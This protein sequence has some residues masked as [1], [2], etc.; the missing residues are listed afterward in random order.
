MSE[1]WDHFWRSLRSPFGEVWDHLVVP[2]VLYFIMNG[3]LERGLKSLFGEVWNHFL[4]PLVLYSAMKGL[5]S[6]VWDH[7]LARFEITIWRGLR[8]PFDTF[9]F[10][11]KNERCFVNPLGNPSP[12]IFSS[13]APPALKKKTIPVFCQT[14][15]CC[16][17]CLPVCSSWVV[18]LKR[19]ALRK[20]RYFAH[21]YLMI[22]NLL[23]TAF[24][25][26]A[27]ISTFETMPSAMALIK[28]DIRFNPCLTPACSG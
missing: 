4:I 16:M 15:K 5:L 17:F 9:C 28:H 7:F 19:N 6:N 27:S 13:P 10:A 11:F 3:A 23:L 24:L 21:R 1:V 26:H 14:E 12:D 18:H 8:S 25:L 22:N 2:F 20:T